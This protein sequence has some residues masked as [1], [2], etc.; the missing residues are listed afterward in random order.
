MRKLNKSLVIAVLVA[1]MALATIG[2]AVLAQDPTALPQQQGSLPQ[3]IDQLPIDDPLV[4]PIHGDL[5]GLAPI[6]LFSGTRDIIN[7]D[8][9][10]LVR[11]A[12]AAHF[13]LDYH[14]APGM[15]HVYPLLPVPEANEARA[16]ME[17]VLKG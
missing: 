11:K 4:S 1:V 10:S 16:V 12:R 7:A 6:T 9:R 3:G 8:A 5:S 13:P 15:L 2:G 14:E 17:K